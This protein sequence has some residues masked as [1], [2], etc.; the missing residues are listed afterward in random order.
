[1]D[2]RF[3]DKLCMKD[4]R[5]ALAA[6][7]LQ[8]RSQLR[9]ITFIDILRSRLTEATYTTPKQATQTFYNIIRTPDELYIAFTE[10]VRHEA[11]M[12]LDHSYPHPERRSIKAAFSNFMLKL[13]NIYTIRAK[14]EPIVPV[15]NYAMT[16]FTD[17]DDEE[18]SLCAYMGGWTLKRSRELN[19]NLKPLV[20]QLGEDHQDPLTKSYRFLPHEPFVHYF[21]ELSSAVWTNLNFEFYNKDPKTMPERVVSSLTASKELNTKLGHI[22]QSTRD[23]TSTLYETILKL[24]VKSAVNQFLKAFHIT[25]NKQSQ[26]LRAELANPTLTVTPASSAKSTSSAPSTSSVPSTSSA[27]STAS[28]PSTL[29]ATPATGG[30]TARRATLAPKQSR[31]K[32]LVKDCLQGCKSRD[33][34]WIQCDKCDHWFHYRCVGIV[35]APPDDM[36]WI[37]G[38]C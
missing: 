28:A 18:R 24:I 29:R 2:L 35:V 27:P 26:S 14:V 13:M 6:T 33:I 30:T 19:G 10:G 21:H 1:M 4:V 32:S 22:I 16:A 12:S 20:E 7:N 31:K 38:L 17:L 15:S 9:M 25:P 5:E 36:R 8:I 3:A 23:E 37:C 11:P 34:D